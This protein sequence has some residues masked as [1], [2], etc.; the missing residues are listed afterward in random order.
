MRPCLPLVV[1][2]R[3]AGVGL[4]PH[5]CPHPGWLSELACRRSAILLWLFVLFK[6]KWHLGSKNVQIAHLSSK[7]IYDVRHSI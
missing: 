4:Y 1:M 2:G 6:G 5:H 3:Q 7:R